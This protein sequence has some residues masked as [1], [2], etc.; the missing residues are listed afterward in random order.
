VYAGIGEFRGVIEDD[1]GMPVLLSGP[2][3]RTFM[4]RLDAAPE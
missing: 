3:E 1:V 4:P 2:V